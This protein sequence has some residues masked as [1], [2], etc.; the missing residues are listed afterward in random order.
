M[1]KY[2]EATPETMLAMLEE[3]AAEHCHAIGNDLYKLQKQNIGWVLVSGGLHMERYPSYK[4]EIK[5][6]TWLSSY[7]A[8][9]GIR[10]NIIYDSDNN[11]IGRGRGLWLFYDISR[12]R[13]V[14]IWEEI[15]EKWSLNPAVSSGHNLVSK[16]EPV[17]KSDYTNEIRVRS[18]EIDM[19]HHV[20]NVM[21]LHWLIDSVPDTIV[22]NYFLQEIQGRFIAEI[23]Y[24]DNMV[25]LTEEDAGGKAFSH[26]IIN[27]DTKKISAV[28]TTVWEKRK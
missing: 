15:K 13:P 24:G 3:T 10:E 6:R 11:I 23:K 26:T 20:N 5:I 8:V 16:L 18:S 12:R 27:Q 17:N 1:S 14:A 7:S 25:F 22:D 2:G 28:A 4:E 9:R 19:Y 21:Y